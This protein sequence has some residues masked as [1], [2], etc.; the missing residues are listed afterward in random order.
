MQ[1][2]FRITALSMLFAMVFLLPASSLP[3]TLQ[4]A[5]ARPGDVRPDKPNAPLANTLYLPVVLRPPCPASHPL[6]DIGEVTTGN[7][8]TT[9]DQNAYSFCGRA[10][11]TMRFDISRTS[12]SLTPQLEI[13]RANGSLICEKFSS[14]RA[15][16]MEC[17]LDAN[18]TYTLNVT[19]W[20]EN[21]TGGYAFYNQKLNNPSGTTPAIFGGVVS[22]SLPS[23]V[24]HDTFFFVALAGDVVRLDMSRTS[25]TITPQ[26]DIYRPDG[27]RLCGDFSSG[28]A[29]TIDCTLDVGGAFTILTGDWS[30][31]G[32]GG[33]AFYLQRLNNPD[34]AT[35]INFADV[36]SG[37]ITSI[38][39]HDTYTFE[40]V[41]G[42]AFRL[43]MSRTSGV[44]TPQV[45]IYRPDGTRL[46]G[47]FS[48]GSALTVDCTLDVG[49]AFTILTG[50][51]GI[52]GSGGYAFYLQ[53]LNNP[54]GAVPINFGDV[55][56]GS[57]TSIV[58]HDSYT[59][60]ATAGDAFRLDMSRTSGIITPQVDIY[61]PDGSRLCGDFSSGSALTVDCTT[62]VNGTYTILAGD[63]SIN[64]SGGYAFYLQRLNNPTGAVPINFGDVQTGSIT[65]IVQHDSYTF[66][67]TAGDAF[68]LDMSRTSGTITPQVDIYR[69]DGSRLCGDFSSGSALTVDCT[70][71]V[72]GTYTILAGDWGINGSGG[73][74]FYL[75][76]LNNPTGAVAI[77]FGDVQT[78]S[79]TSIVQHDSYTF[80]ATAGDAF[81][82]DMSRT[83]GVITPQ[84]DI[85]RPD[86]SRLCGDFSSGSALTVDCTTDVNG[87]Y[88]ILA[89]DWSINGSG[90]YAFYLQRLNN[91]TG[92]VPINFGDVQSGSTTSIV[93][94]DTYTF[95]AATG[96]AIHIEMSR[97]SGTITPQV[98]V[99]R[100]DGTRLCG[101]FS[102]GTS[103][104]V[105]C[106]V[107]STG[108]FTILAGDWSLNGS[109]G[110][111][112]SLN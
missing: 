44:I 10:G 56:T 73:Y 61:R 78:G 102:S 43:D 67:A 5:A 13:L 54:T 94:H 107:D 11:D 68:R 46:C 95:D 81:R 28:S 91:P 30:L 84:V 29:L 59:F 32:S 88:I 82:L 109:G 99:Y 8:F 2:T 38:V 4:S 63:W 34:A 110:Y 35:P 23:I 9:S 92:A 70:L 20:G 31:N 64:G 57:I 6:L 97:T 37:S 103:V 112:L 105:D 79:I 83:S 12:G 89:G 14:G 17:T 25:G 1:R 55:Q 74:A 93:Q 24:S 49:G 62:D 77:N 40:A 90:G 27:T 47:D 65:S 48:S 52:N 60:E 50:D 33:Y 45:D 26:V 19:D 96:N 76:R 104:I 36:Q 106:T 39:R 16:S 71:D 100:P 21:G 98:D 22:G 108:T 80:E 111:V 101:D 87:T 85:Y 41:A 58:Q 53:R 75:Q 42:D 86:G 7:I 3:S 69:P 66:E 18:G 72:N 51:W 15:F